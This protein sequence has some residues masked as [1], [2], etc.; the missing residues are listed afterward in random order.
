VIS[1]GSIVLNDTEEVFE[2][3][4]LETVQSDLFADVVSF[5]T[6]FYTMRNGEKHPVLKLSAEKLKI[7][8]ICGLNLKPLI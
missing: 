4:D 2:G 5:S 8:I 6:T 7:L 3:G 1:N